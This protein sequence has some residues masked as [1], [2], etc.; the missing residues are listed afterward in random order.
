[1]PRV[2][3]LSKSVFPLLLSTSTSLSD[4]DMPSDAFLQLP[5]RTSYGLYFA[6][7]SV[8]VPR[9]RSPFTDEL[10]NAVSNFSTIVLTFL[11]P[12]KVW[13]A[14]T[15]PIGKP[16]VGT[17]TPHCREPELYPSPGASSND[18]CNR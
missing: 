5:S 17:P 7:V 4:F 15:Q 11:A 6:V 3:S 1:M 8:S 10:L 2:L 13:T 16:P 14:H 12:S 18:D 9:V